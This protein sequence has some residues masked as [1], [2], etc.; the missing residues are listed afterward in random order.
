M[1]LLTH[2]AIGATAIAAA[3]IASPVGA[4][5]LGWLTHYLADAVPHGDE[6]VGVWARGPGGVRKLAAAAFADCGLIAM[7][8]AIGYVFDRLSWPLAAAA[9]GATVPDFMLGFERIAGRRLFGPLGPF[10]ERLHN[11]LKIDFPLPVGLVAQGLLAVLLW[12]RLFGA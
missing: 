5:G 6:A 8:L 2:A 11:F 3:G 9:V 4:F 12:W 1:F 10:H 7:T